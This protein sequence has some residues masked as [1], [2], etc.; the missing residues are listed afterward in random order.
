VASD[1]QEVDVDLVPGEYA[2]KPARGLDSAVRWRPLVN[3]HEDSLQLDVA[4]HLSEKAPRAGSN[5]QGQPEAQIGEG[6]LTY[7]LLGLS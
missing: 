6:S 7:I 2:T 5:E 1:V 3:R 4:A